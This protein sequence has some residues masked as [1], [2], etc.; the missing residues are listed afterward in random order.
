MDNV[1]MA[2]VRFCYG[3]GLIL[4][5]TVILPYTGEASPLE[6]AY[7]KIDKLTPKP[8][9]RVPVQNQSRADFREFLINQLNTS[10]SNQELEGLSTTFSLLGALNDTYAL[11][12]NLIDLYRN[13]AAA[14]YDPKENVIR[15]VEGNFPDSA[16]YFIYLHELVHAYQDQHYDL[17]T[18]QKRLQNRSYDAKMAF[19]FVVEGHANLL[20]TLAMIGRTD[21]TTEY[22]RNGTHRGVFDVLAGFTTLAPTQLRLMGNLNQSTSVMARQLRQLQDVPDALLQMMLDPYLVGQSLW[23]DHIAQAGWPEAEDWLNQPPSSTRNL[24][25]Q[26][27]TN[28]TKER[29]NSPRNVSFETSG[30][31]Y[32]LLR[33]TRTLDERPSWGA[34]VQN[35]RLQVLESDN[36]T[37]LHWQ[38]TFS[39]TSSARA[40]VADVTEES[41]SSV[42]D[43]FTRNFTVQRYAGTRFVQIHREGN[44]VNL[45]LEDDPD[46]ERYLEYNSLER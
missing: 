39:R 22:F 17:L 46:R 5:L 27:P 30:G 45:F 12:P 32:S 28:G 19:T 18:R 14:Y 8:L 40:M 31:V 16:L 20:A 15:K 44:R 6:R 11:K 29:S 23:Y 9:S 21:I 41:V 43:S 3:I 25:Y 24:F 13:Q 37:F 36:D 33:W 1:P 26:S 7:T 42:N 34:H 4:V 35:D 10:F 38:I 2:F